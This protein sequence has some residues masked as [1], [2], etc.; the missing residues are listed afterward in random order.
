M[1]IIFIITKQVKDQ[2]RK[3]MYWK[4]RSKETTHPV[5]NMVQLN[6]HSIFSNRNVVIYRSKDEGCLSYFHI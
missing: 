5:N 4:L 6:D 1:F 2:T 3:Q